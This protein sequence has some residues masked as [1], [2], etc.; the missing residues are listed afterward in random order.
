MTPVRTGLTDY[1]WSVVQ[2]GLS[3]G[4]QVLILPTSGLLAD[5]QRRQQ[6]IQQRVGGGPLGRN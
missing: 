3:A 2:E 6:W 1:D 4:D 5:Q